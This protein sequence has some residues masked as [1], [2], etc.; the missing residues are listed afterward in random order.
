MKLGQFQKEL[1]NYVVGCFGFGLAADFL[2]EGV[3]GG[4]F[5]DSS[6][7]FIRAN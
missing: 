7:K 3:E 6:N 2:V 5:A 1:K 4:W